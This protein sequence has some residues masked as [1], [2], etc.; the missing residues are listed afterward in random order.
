MC[1]RGLLGKWGPNHAADPIVTRWRPGSTAIPVKDRPLQV[2][3]ITRKDTGEW[4]M[5]GGMVDSDEIVSVTVRR[6]FTEEAGNIQDPEQRALFN[7]LSDQVDRYTR[8]IR[9]IRY[10]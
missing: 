10:S 2:V 9:H 1:E 8:Y 4:A 7:Q 5:P 6:E 3:A